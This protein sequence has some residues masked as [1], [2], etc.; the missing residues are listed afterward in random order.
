MFLKL[1]TIIA[2]VGVALSFL[3][4]FIQQVMFAARIYS[5]AFVMLTRLMSM[6]EIVLLNGSLLIF[7][8]AFLLSL[9]AKTT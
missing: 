9:R 3:L 2:I 8:V 5:E 1:A 4:S 7:F 6:L